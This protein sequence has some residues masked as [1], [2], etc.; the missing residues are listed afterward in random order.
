MKKVY[1][2]IMSLV[3]LTGCNDFINLNPISQSSAN[4]FYSTE[5]EMEQGLAAAYDNLQASD[6]YG[7]NGFPSFM[8]VPSDNTWNLNTTQNGGRS[9]AFDNFVVD[10]N[11]AQL[12]STW[13][14]C[15]NG[16]QK[17]NLVITR[18]NA[19]TS[20]T[21][22]SKNRIL[23]EAYF[24]RALTYFNMVR[25]WGNIPLITKEVDNVN[26]AFNHTQSE[27][28]E[29]YAQIIKDLE[30][31]ISNLPARHTGKNVGRATKGA[32]QTLLAKVY[33]T[34]SEWA[35]AKSLLTDII[36]SGIYEL[37]PNFADV[38]SVS[39]KNNVESIFEVQFDKEI[40]GEGYYGGDPLQTGNDVNNLPSNNLISLFNENID[41]RKDAT[42]INLGTQ[43]MRLY[44]WHDTKGSNGG[45]GFNIIVLRYADVLL[46]AAETLNEL[47]YGDN[48][49]LNYLN[50]VRARSHA[51]LYTFEELSNQ[52]KFR[53]AVEKERRLE[54]AFENHRW[55]DL[56]RTGKALETV[57]KN[58]GGS[59]LTVNAQKHQLLFPIPQGQIDASGNKLQQNDGYK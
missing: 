22:A 21:E 30:F 23:G 12:A 3:A 59:V 1:L 6:Q 20:I 18:L 47:S 5:Y 13:I 40:Q 39:N 14:S 24:L 28:A 15:Y 29:V 57:N 33:M 58:D 45:M 46:M 4:G 53:D 42:I 49:A 56:L 10:P 50:M 54:L 37:V 17:V 43:G 36:S 25:I 11:N 41:D 19:S 38:F 52:V 7:G 26:D 27:P 35:K 48:S 44:K 8:E 9:A 31:S 51:P 34:H 55:F 16:I 32:A 2:M